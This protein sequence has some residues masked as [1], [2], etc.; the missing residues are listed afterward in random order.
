MNKKLQTID[1][2]N[3]SARALAEKF[4]NLDF[5]TTP[6]DIKEAFDLLGKSNAKVL[7]I[8]CGSGRDAK[9]ILKYT[10]DYLGIDI[11]TELISI[12]QEKSPEA[13]FIVAD[14]T[15]F[16]F[17]E[18]IDIVFAF[19]SLIHVNK[20]EFKIVLG[21]LYK[22]LNPKGLVVMSMKY[23]DIYKEVTK[24]DE[25]GTRTYYHYSKEDIVELSSDFTIL[26][27]ELMELRGQKWLEI[28]LQKE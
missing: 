17:P 2:Y 1:T 4:D 22:A 18:G 16:E 28:I 21:K 12:A 27:N 9:E 3:K 19:A 5:G 11:S 24:D 23:S 7:E 14:V 10:D 6:T 26:R 8:G 25:F 15:S 20:E 13:N